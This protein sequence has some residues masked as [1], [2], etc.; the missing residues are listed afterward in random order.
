MDWQLIVTGVLTRGLTQPVVMST[1]AIS[2]I[3][4]P[5]IHS[6]HSTRSLRKSNGGIPIAVEIAARLP[7]IQ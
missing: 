6:L 7:V 5:R 1:I 2:H 3:D 4:R